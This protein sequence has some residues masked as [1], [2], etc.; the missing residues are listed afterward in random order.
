MIENHEQWRL[1]SVC[2]DYS[3]SSAGRVRRETRKR[4]ARAGHMIATWNSV[5][6]YPKA[7]LSI[8]GKRVGFNLHTLVATAFCSR[9]NEP[10]LVVNHKNGVKTDNRAENLEWVSQAENVR[11]AVRTG[12]HRS[13]T[14]LSVSDVISIRSRARAGERR[15]SIARDFNVSMAT[16][17]DIKLGKRRRNAA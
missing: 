1:C 16:I 7:F 11:H 4:G 9:G 14:K 2:P 10:G 13:V 5:N 15:R 8:N 17:S 6:G 12:L 3:V